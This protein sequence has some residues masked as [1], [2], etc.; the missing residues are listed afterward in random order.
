MS[1]QILGSKAHIQC[2]EQTTLIGPLEPHMRIRYLLNYDKSTNMRKIS[3]QH[4][5][6]NVSN[7]LG[8]ETRKRTVSELSPCRMVGWKCKTSSIILLCE[9]WLS[10]VCIQGKYY[11]YFIYIDENKI[12][13]I[14]KE[15][16]SIFS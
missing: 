15:N 2:L 9:T 3:V 13:G 1:I 11:C 16:K 14:S 4:T 6:V 5:M 8:S 10:T 12:S 7:I